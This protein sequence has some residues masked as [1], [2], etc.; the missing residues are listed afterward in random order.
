M[1]RF[2]LL[3]M[4][5]ALI[6]LEPVY[7]LLEYSS[8]K[9]V[10]IYA[11][12]VSSS[13]KGLVSK[14]T[15]AVAY[16]GSGRVFFS[17][18]P[19]TEVETQG[20]ARVAAYIA[21]VVAGL[22]YSNYDYYVLVESNTPIIGGP[23]AG[24]LFTVGF[25]ALLLDLS[26]NNTVTMTGMINPD[27]TIG[28][29]GGLKEKLEAASSSGFRVF[30]IPAGQRLYTY[31]VYE[32]TS[33]GWITI[34]RVTYRTIDLVE[35]GKSLNITVVEVNTIL[36]ALYF[37]TGVE[38]GKNTTS[39]HVDVS[40][41][42]WRS[43]SEKVNEVSNQV[44]SYINLAYSTVS[45]LN[46]IYY[47][48]YYTQVLNNINK[49]LT[50][51]LRSPAEYSS[52]VLFKLIDLYEDALTTYFELGV[53]TGKVNIEATLNS[54]LQVLNEYS[55]KAPSACG[56]ESSLA[57][58]HLY[59][60]WYYYS[61][62]VSALNSSSSVYDAISSIARG[63]RSLL[64]YAVYRDIGSL[65]SREV[66]CSVQRLVQVYSNALASYIYV[67]RTLSEIGATVP[68]D[69]VALVNDY[70]N[71]AT[72]MS[73]KNDTGILGASVLILSY[74]SLLLHKA[75]GDTARVANLERL[76]YLHIEEA[77][78]IPLYSLYLNLTISAR[79]LSDSDMYYKALLLTVA[80]M[81]VTSQVTRALGGKAPENPLQT[82][83]SV[84]TAGRDNT[85]T[86]SN[87]SASAVNQAKFYVVL[88]IIIVTVTT[89][90]LLLKRSILRSVTG[91]PI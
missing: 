67:S 32:E 49:T 40:S 3:I 68:N 70:V 61:Q 14:I 10:E 87:P 58:T 9:V 12:A 24:A 91:M 59:L 1:K 38:L 63:Y 83:T 19:Y 64:E 20:A 48:Y 79:S 65:S 35:Y 55:E 47:K 34:R 45:E 74:T 43:L 86:T 26:L 60:A 22:D 52:C 11:P 13:G 7:S 5:L 46:N 53:M 16:P 4:L 50:D 82:Y 72:Q 62:A 69:I 28:P 37:F 23:S 42:L 29:V 54:L 88:V 18:L 71:A 44:A 73:E 57:R 36:D 15:L 75:L 81:Q 41:E 84:T 56:L 33:R 85:T 66:D 90:L 2:W 27:G 30:L 31:P 77:A 89:V 17:A 21:S 78:K 39:T 8:V 76:A 25:T 51:L 6:V 80:T